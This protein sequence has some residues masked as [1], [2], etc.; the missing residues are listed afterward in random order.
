V[1]YVD[2]GL[3]KDKILGFFI[4]IVLVGR[5]MRKGQSVRLSAKEVGFYPF[6]ITATN[7]LLFEGRRLSQIVKSFS[8]RA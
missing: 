6:L 1:E 2:F 7:G 5:L 3:P 4:Q 8:M